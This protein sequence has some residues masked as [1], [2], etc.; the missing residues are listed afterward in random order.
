[1][2]LDGKIAIV[3]GGASGIGASV[4]TRYCAE[5]A[6]VIVVDRNGDAAE[7]HAS[8]LSRAQFMTVDVA[9]VSEVDEAVERVVGEHG[10]LDVVA[11]VAGID[12]RQTK[13]AIGEHLAAG[14]PLDITSK[15]TDD[16]WRRMMSVNLDGVFHFVRAALRVMLAQ[17][18]GS[19]INVSSL[20]G[21]AGQAGLPHYSAAK[22][23]V[24]AFTRAVSKEVADRGVRVNA[25]APGAIQ[26][27]MF[28]RSP[29]GLASSIPMKRIGQPDEVASVAAF[30][31]SDDSSY[32]TGETINVN[33]GILTL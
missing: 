14:T 33:G 22:A 32:I 12:D 20:A 30:L 7:K 9:V 27:P 21:V 10:R 19:I 25:I 31:A 8:T 26:T 28:G 6:T 4:C 29:A 16:Q 2:L 23:G 24:L 13:A 11:N 1:V 17:Q 3:T 15:L 18:A 5:G